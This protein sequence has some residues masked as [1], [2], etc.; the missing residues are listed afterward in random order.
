MCIPVND[1]SVNSYIERP[2]AHP[3]IIPGRKRP[4][5]TFVP[6]VVIVSRYQTKR[7]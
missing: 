5:G 3:M 2:R 7:K 1:Q 6:Y 4:A